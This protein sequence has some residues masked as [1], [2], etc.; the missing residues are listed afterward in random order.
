MPAF[1]EAAILLVLTLV[2]RLGFIYVVN[3]R[4]HLTFVK[5]PILTFL[6][7][8]GMALIIIVLFPRY[9]GLLYAP[10]SILTVIFFLF[11]L[12][13]V[14]PWLYRLLKKSKNLPAKLA[15]ANPEQQ[16]LLID[17]RYLISK[18]GDVVFQQTAMGVLLWILVEM[19]V[20]FETLVPTFAIIFAAL[21]LHLFFS[22]KKVWATYFTVSAGAAGFMFPFLIL[23]VP[24]GVYFATTIH[25]L[26]YVGSGA[27]FG[28]VERETM[29]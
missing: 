10:G 19:G 24:G 26:W 18:T 21:H 16:F 7:F 23:A 17:E 14:N 4:L 8:I 13:V 29:P 20:A 9:A 1:L 22:A 28:M 25:M 3:R 12:V 27:L 6:Y 2:N 15:K 11:M 5:N